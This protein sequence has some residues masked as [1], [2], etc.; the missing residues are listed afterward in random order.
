MHSAVVGSCLP[1]AWKVEVV[2]LFTVILS[3]T[4]NYRRAN[5][6]YIIPCLKNQSQTKTKWGE[7]LIPLKGYCSMYVSHSGLMPTC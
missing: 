5:V 4:Q 2:L 6:R 7:F 3:Y 1:S